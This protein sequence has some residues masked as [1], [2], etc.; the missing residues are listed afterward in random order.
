MSR[1][2]WA[3]TQ[4]ER[5]QVKSLAGRGVPEKMIASIMGVDKLTLR[6]HCPE[7]LTS[8]RALAV[9]N[10]MGKSYEQAMKGEFKFAQLFLANMAGWHLTQKLEHTV[11]VDTARLE[12]AR[13]RALSAAGTALTG[14]GGAPADD[15]DGD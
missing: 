15:G 2:P 9:A 10:V 14:D 7:E 8:G 13:A 6:K 4:K 11:K 3:P 5:E 1:K 12:R